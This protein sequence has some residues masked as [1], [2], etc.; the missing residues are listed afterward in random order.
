MKK[1]NVREVKLI[2]GGGD[3]PGFGTCVIGAYGAVAVGA[4]SG[5]AAKFGP[6]AMAG[7]ALAAE[8]TYMGENGCFG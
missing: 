2:N 3:Y 5:K 7:S 1:L 4:L 8:I 6:I